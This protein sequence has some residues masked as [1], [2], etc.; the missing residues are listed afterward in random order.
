MS[1]RSSECRDGLDSLRSSL[2]AAC[3]PTV[4]V[5]PVAASGVHEQRTVGYSAFGQEDFYGLV[6]PTE[7][8]DLPR[9]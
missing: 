1:P 8:L 3:T 4:T 2:R 7:L 9:R 5:G 6:M